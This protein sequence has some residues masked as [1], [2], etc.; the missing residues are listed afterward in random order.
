MLALPAERRKRV[1]LLG[2]GGGS[3]A[4]IVRALAPGAAITGVE[5]DADVVR[6]ARRHFDLDALG[7]ETVT[8]D[9]RDYL[10]R[11]RGRFDAILEDCFVGEEDELAKPEG[12]PDPAFARAAA[13]L[14]PGGV[15]VSNA[16]DEAPGIARTLG[17]L[18]PRVVETRIDGYD[19]RVFVGGP[20]PLS[21][22][23]LRGAVAANEVLAPTLPL[24]A[25]RRVR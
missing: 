24:L 3:A 23:R 22:R 18:F 5:I 14:R 8:A 4:R 2:L 1:L 11:T 16:L 7:V 10:A 6:L 13:R 15:L 25:F 9:A 19:N 17:G 21:G 12:I 20:A